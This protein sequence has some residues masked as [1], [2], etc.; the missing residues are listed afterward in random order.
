M[1]SGIRLALLMEIMTDIR[2]NGSR[3]SIPVRFFKDLDCAADALL[4]LPM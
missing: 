4:K 2:K 1:P 3:F